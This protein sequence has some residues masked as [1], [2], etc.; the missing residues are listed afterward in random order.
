MSAFGNV[1][2]GV[3]NVLC[4]AMLSCLIIRQVLIAW[5]E[6]TCPAR[7]TYEN[8]ARNIFRFSRDC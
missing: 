3:V 6:N 5:M 1:T 8:D 7:E 2:D 4:S